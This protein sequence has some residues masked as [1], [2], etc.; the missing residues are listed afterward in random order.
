MFKVSLSLLGLSLDRNTWNT[1][2]FLP[3]SQ[4]KGEVKDSLLK[5]NC[6]DKSRPLFFTDDLPSSDLRGKT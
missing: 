5:R 2:N 6:S 3:Q 4:G 1:V